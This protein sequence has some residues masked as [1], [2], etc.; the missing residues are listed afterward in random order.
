MDTPTFKSFHNPNLADL[1]E[2]SALKTADQVAD[3]DGLQPKD[4]GDTSVK[5][6]A[7]KG[8]DPAKCET[9]G[10]SKNAVAHTPAADTS[11]E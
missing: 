9:C 6:H 11:D 8:D 5:H 4:N 7:F 3:K 2:R 10:M 1:K